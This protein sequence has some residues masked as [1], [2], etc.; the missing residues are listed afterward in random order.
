[1]KS[2]APLCTILF[3]FSLMIMVYDLMCPTNTLKVLS[4]CLF[5]ME[6][7]AHSHLR[8]LTHILL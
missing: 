1:M 8:Y 5:K 3:V 7:A 6:S 4:N 2:L